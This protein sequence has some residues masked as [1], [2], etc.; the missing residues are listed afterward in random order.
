MSIKT[1]V[2]SIISD[3]LYIAPSFNP[4]QQIVD[5]L[6]ADEIDILNIVTELENHFDVVILDKQ[7]FESMRAM[8]LVGVIEDLVDEKNNSRS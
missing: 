7:I 6:G 5:D 2:L 8:H 4:E 3:V 1:A